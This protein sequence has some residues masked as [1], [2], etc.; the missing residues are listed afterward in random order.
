MHPQ[1][2]ANLLLFV[3]SYLSA[4]LW[5]EGNDEEEDSYCFSNLSREVL[6]R[7]EQDARIFFSLAR[8][9][10]IDLG[11][12]EWAGKI[13]SVAHDFLLTRNEHGAGFWDG[14]WDEPL[15]ETFTE[16]SHMM[17]VVEFYVGDD[18]LVYL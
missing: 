13:G 12:H 4:V 5:I 2:R 3:G 18:G 1:E 7:A 9:Q 17:G 11:K 8:D 10:G 14:D 16:I 6:E 15:D